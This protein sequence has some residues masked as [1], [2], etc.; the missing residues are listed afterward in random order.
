MRRLIVAKGP[1]SQVE[2]K[3]DYRNKSFALLNLT[4]KNGFPPP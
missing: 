4:E 1:V 2:A 3:A